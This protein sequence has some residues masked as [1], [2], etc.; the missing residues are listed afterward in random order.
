MVTLG[1][2]DSFR[3]KCTPPLKM[4]FSVSS[5]RINI[6]LG[7]HILCAENFKD[8]TEMENFHEVYLPKKSF[9]NVCFNKRWY[10]T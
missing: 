2:W 3:F 5:P 7:T 9:I 10:G 4:A 1:L 6:L 8:L